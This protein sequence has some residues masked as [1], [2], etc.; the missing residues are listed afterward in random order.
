MK[1]KANKA[2]A[3]A[4]KT[5]KAGKLQEAERQYRAILAAMPGNPDANH[6]LGILVLTAGN[7]EEALPYLKA[8]LEADARQQRFWLSYINGLIDAGQFTEARQVLQSGRSSGL[9][10]D[11]VDQLERKLAAA[12]TQTLPAPSDV[13]DRQ[14]VD[15]LLSAYRSGNTNEAERLAR[16][17]CEQ[18]PDHPLG[19]K[20]LGTT[21]NLAG[22]TEASIEPL[23]RS[24]RLAPRDCETHNILGVAL[25][26]LRRFPEAEASCREAIRLRP[27]F[28]EGHNSLGNVLSNLGQIA[29]AEASFRE[30]IRLRPDFPEAHNNLGNALTSLDRITEAEASYREAVRLKQ[31]FVEALYNLATAL[32]RLGKLDEAIACDSRVLEIRPDYASAEAR[33]LHLK[34]HICD[35]SNFEQLDE[36]CARLGSAASAMTPFAMLST[37]DN[38]DRQLARSRAWAADQFRQS[39]LPLPAK[40]TVRP[41]RLRVGYFSVNLHD[42][43][44]LY[45]MAGLLRNHDHEKFEIF[46]YSYG[47]IKSGKW[48]ERVKEDVD[49]FFDVHEQADRAI[50]DLARSHSLDIAID[51]TGYT[52][53][54]RSRLFQYRLAP[55]QINYLGYPGTMGADFIDYIIA[56]PTIIPE[57][58]ARS[59]SEKK[60]YL[61]HSYM[62]N[63]NEREIA[64]SGM[65]RAE[66]GLP[67]DAV[68]LCCFNQ[69]YKISP[70]E[71][72]IWMR[73]LSQ[74]DRAVLWL[75]ASYKWAD[76]NL[77][78]EAEARGI[79]ASRLIFAGRLPHAEHLARHRLADLFL[80]T[81]NYNA[82]TT[83]SD[84]LWAGLPVVTKQGRQF[85]ARVAASLLNAVGLPELIATTEADYERLILDLASHPGKLGEIREKLAVNRLS[86]PLFDTRRYTR[87]F[88]SGLREAYDLYYDGEDARDILVRNSH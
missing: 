49:H 17:M 2:L 3:R 39:P 22:K 80:D 5:H 1:I 34:Q 54:T 75:K 53:D 29:Q 4:I 85:S 26:R 64:S 19:W 21:L 45:L 52:Q 30:A 58:W 12:E 42:H 20:V 43:A 57:E 61:P 84:A 71:F 56:D 74:V 15:A 38:P 28:P 47:S 40:P 25:G 72:D 62:P 23:Q 31:D 10:G 50:V 60:I 51:L 66:A 78:R 83:A 41:E 76:E 24:I 33:M 81:F 16:S 59:Y 63:D 88:E 70:R 18:F 73:V 6:N 32:H 7:P 9:A 11:P 44:L 86:E 14:A 87:D 77:R 55:I 36:A 79:S 37:E 8:A 27:D 13:P 46:A 82:H 67:E 68:V 65:A 35:W 48:R 69:T